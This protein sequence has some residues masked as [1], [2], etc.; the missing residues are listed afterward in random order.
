[1]NKV[2]GSLV[3]TA[4]AGMIV[5]GSAMAAGAKKGD[6]AAKKG[7]W[8]ESV[9]C[10]GKVEGATNSCKSQKACASV[11]KEQCEAKD[12]EGKAVGKWHAK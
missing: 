12:A 1:M 11:T 7:P 2:F 9:G 6:K 3:A 8:C 4:V 5:S 10:A